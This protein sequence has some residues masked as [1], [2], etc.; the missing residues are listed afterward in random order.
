MGKISMKQKAGDGVLVRRGVRSI[1]TNTFDWWIDGRAASD[2]KLFALGPG[3]R[4]NIDRRSS[5]ALIPRRDIFE[6][7]RDTDGYFEIFSFRDACF[8]VR[9][10]K[11]I[12]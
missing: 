7:A 6:L 3:R 12:D 8:F 1:R 5:R 10:A 2:T 11:D 9:V 4:W